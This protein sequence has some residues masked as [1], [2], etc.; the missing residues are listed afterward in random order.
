MGRDYSDDRDRNQKRRAS[1]ACMN[2]TCHR[3]YHS[4]TRITSR[5]H[6]ENAI[7]LLVISAYYI[8]L[9]I[10]EGVITKQEGANPPP[11]TKLAVNATAH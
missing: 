11:P 9:T 6:N 10:A 5:F 1:V 7:K 4:T 8:G 2:A 3:I